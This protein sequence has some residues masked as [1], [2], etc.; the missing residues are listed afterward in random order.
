MPIATTST[1]LAPAGPAQMLGAG[2]AAARPRATVRRLWLW[3]GLLLGLLLGGVP[4]AGATPTTAS[5]ERPRIALVLS[6]G[7]ARGF[8][9]VG[10]LQVLEAARVPVDMVVGTSMGAIIG[11]LYASGMTPDA[12]QQAILEVDW[13]GLFKDRVPRQEMSQRRKEEDFIF[14]PAV[15][16]GYKNGEFQLPKGTVSSRSLEL[17]LRRLTLH[18]QSLHTFD[19]LPLPYRAL[20]TDLVSGKPL[21]LSSGDLAAAMRA[22]MS[23]PGVFAPLELNDQLLGDGGLVNNLPI[24]VAR[25]LGAD[26]VIAVNIGSPLLKRKD[27]D[28]VVGVTLQMINILTEQNVQQN[29]QR[30][31]PNDLLISPD[32]GELASTDFNKGR[33]LMD[34][35]RE[36]AR[37]LLPQLERFALPAAM[38]ADWKA[39]KNHQYQALLSQIPQQLAFVKVEGVDPKQVQRLERL[40]DVQTGQALDPKRI[41]QDLQRLVA[42]DDYVH[43]NYRLERTPDNAG[44][45]LVYQLDE[46]DATL[47]QFRVGLDLQTDFQGQGNFKLRVSHTLHDRNRSGAQWRNQLELGASEALTSEWYQPIG[48]DR[49]LFWSVY[50]DHELRKVEWFDNA[51][52]PLAIFRKRNTRLGGDIGWHLGRGGAWGDLRA[53][54]LTAR[55]QIMVDYSNLG[56]TQGSLN[57]VVWSEWA[58]RFSWISDQLDHAHFP[59]E[60]HRYKFE[61]Q[62]G[63]SR[64]RS[65]DQQT[66]NRWTA[67]A[68]EVFSHGP[69]TWNL[70]TRAS[71]TSET[72]N[73]VPDEYA[74]GGFQQLS[75]Y[76]VGQIAGN[77]VF[78]G[79][80]DYYRRLPLDLG[81]TRAVFGGATL[82]VGGAWSGINRSTRQRSS[83]GL[84]LGSSLYLGADTGIGPVYLSL[85]HAPQ[86]HT[87]LYFLLGKP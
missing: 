1:L 31:G 58:A 85:V 67:Q 19:Q 84:R 37:K 65:S 12:M 22:S 72:I 57:E 74:L 3:L 63:Q 73:G 15:K 48:Q 42:L 35:G 54:L 21:L 16:L 4:E 61:V 13:N 39:A 68:T 24:D 11:G 71:R 20:A 41:E 78:L 40:L 29:L 60:G 76:R 86:G 14:S 46:G 70:Y 32:L 26:V 55:R 28:S 83:S 87:G 18:T 25:Q 53:G 80:L 66:F 50:A 81:V 43:I 82:E 75:G 2:C 34:L 51:G 64:G 7:G 30:L 77:E 5:A 6:G 36:H 17:L 9:H 47:H 44:E 38:Y 52:D 49:R 33:E 27:L 23:V 45:G 56:L 69:S 79:R 8:A 59:H 10:V 62:A